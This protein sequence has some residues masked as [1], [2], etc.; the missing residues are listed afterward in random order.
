MNDEQ[1]G[2]LRLRPLVTEPGPTTRIDVAEAMRR[3]RRARRIRIWSRVSGLSAVTAA[4]AVGGALALSSP[5]VE[6]EPVLPPDPSLPA[7]CTAVRLPMGG[8]SAAAATGGDPSGTYLVGTTNPDLEQGRRVLVWRDGD[9]VADVAQNGTSAVMS[10]INASGVAVGSNTR[11]P[12]L[13]YVFRAGEIT[14][15]EGTGTAESINDAGQ[16]AGTAPG[17]G[18][19]PGIP[20]RWAAPDAQPER[21]MLP[22]G[23]VGGKSTDIAEDG[24][25][26]VTLFTRTYNEQ[27][28]LWLPDGSLRPLD[29]PR[30]A[31]GRVTR[32]SPGYFRSGWLYGTV[33]TFAEPGSGPSAPPRGAYSWEERDHRYHVASGTWQELPDGLESGVT[34]QNMG[35]DTF[36]GKQ[37]FLL[38]EPADKYRD[39]GFVI[40]FVSDDGRTAAGSSLSA[41]ANPDQP[42]GALMWNCR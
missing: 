11:S 36:I 5:A 30:A 41:V 28:Y 24:T 10:D 21:L 27:G 20:V 7:A 35:R 19:G 39:E 3:G 31:N 18:S 25:I 22:A 14:R 8:G 40:N 38:P 37:I 6:P 13:P 16:I 12:F 29:A 23:A 2:T 33:A 4:T 26:A 17:A 1:Y 34:Q 15:L 42:S 9:L 32:F